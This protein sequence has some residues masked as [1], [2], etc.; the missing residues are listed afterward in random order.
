MGSEMC[1]RDRVL[2]ARSSCARICRVR[3]ACVRLSEAKA[4]DLSDL[5]TPPR[6]LPPITTP[7]STGT[8]SSVLC[9]LFGLVLPAPPAVALRLV[10]C[11]TRDFGD[12]FRPNSETERV[13]ARAKRN[14]RERQMHT[15]THTH[16]ERERES[17]RERLLRDI[18]VHLLVTLFRSVER[19]GRRAEGKASVVA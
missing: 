17:E 6:N 2:T 1:I 16:T 5:S 12:V 14:A 18:V 9:V 11:A 4:L 7:K 19:E 10:V 15:H 3:R 8:H 13:R